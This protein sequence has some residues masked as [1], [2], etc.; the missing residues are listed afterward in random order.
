MKDYLKL[1]VAGIAFSAIVI[2]AAQ[3]R[4]VRQ[5]NADRATSWIEAAGYTNVENVRRE[6]NHWEA[7]A[8][9]DDGKQVSVDVDPK[10][11]A[12]TPEDG[13]ERKDEKHE[14]K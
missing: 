3:D 12:V 13:N 10:S 9:D 6:A 8:T 1:F 11:G 2:A 4:S 7:N 14:H 5:V